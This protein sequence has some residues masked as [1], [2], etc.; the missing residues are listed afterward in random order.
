MAD[1]SNLY[2]NTAP[3]I[4]LF[5]DTFFVESRSYMQRTLLG[6]IWWLNR[7]AVVGDSDLFPLIGEVNRL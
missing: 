4:G 1:L 7:G 3:G 5:V 2:Y 6:I